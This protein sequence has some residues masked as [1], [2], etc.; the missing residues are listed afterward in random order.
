MTMDPKEPQVDPD[1]D[2]SDEIDN[3]EFIQCGAPDGDELL[4]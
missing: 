2:Y 3:F 1:T 4:Y